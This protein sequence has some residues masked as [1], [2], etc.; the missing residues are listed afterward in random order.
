MTEGS[1]GLSGEGIY[2]DDDKARKQMP[3]LPMF[4][5][6][7]PEKIPLYL[8]DERLG[9]RTW[10][11]GPFATIEE[12]KTAWRVLC[13]QAHRLRW[14]EVH[15]DGRAEATKN[16]KTNAY[17][18]KCMLV[19][20]AMADVY[21]GIVLREV[22]DSL[23]PPTARP[24]RTAN[25]VLRPLVEPSE[26]SLWVVTFEHA[27][28]FGSLRLAYFHAADMSKKKKPFAIVLSRKEDAAQ[29]VFLELVGRIRDQANDE[30]LARQ[31]AGA[32]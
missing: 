28:S 19:V 17:T 27:L 25:T 15:S 31:M 11:E 1:N 32:V 20:K 24:G 3:E 30:A 12:A 16:L 23:T 8:D 7:D 9:H 21:P 22:P 10:I 13:P 6:D 14:D 29:A 18:A 4:D 2:P 26:F 5:D